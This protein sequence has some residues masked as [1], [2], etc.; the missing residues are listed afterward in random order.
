MR[1]YVLVIALSL[2]LLSSTVYA[3][4]AYIRPPVIQVTEYVKNGV[5]NIVSSFVEVKNRNAVP[6]IVH[7]ESDD[8]VQ[9]E[10]NDFVLQ[11][12][13]TRNATFYVI[14]T[15]WGGF[16]TF[17]DVTYMRAD[18]TG[19]PATVGAPMTISA[20]SNGTGINNGPP[21]AP[22]ITSPPN[23]AVIE[24]T[25]NLKW[26][27][28]SDPDG[29]QIL[30]Y[31]IVDDN[32]D[33]S[34]PVA[35]ISTI[36]LEKSV[37]LE[38]GKSYSWKVI[39]FDGK[40]S[41]SSNPGGGI[42]SND[43]PPTPTP[44]SPANGAALNNAPVLS[45]SSVADPDGDFVI[46][47]LLVDNNADFSSPEINAPA[48]TS[49]NTNGIL[50]AGTYYW[51]VRARDHAEASAYSTARSFTLTC[52]D[53]Y[54]YNIQLVSPVDGNTYNSR[55]ILVELSISRNA[56]SIYKALN[57][58]TFTTICSDCSEVSKA[59]AAREGLNNLTIKIVGYNGEEL[60]K[61]IFFTVDT[62]EPRISKIEPD[63]ESW[64]SGTLFMVKYT[65]NNIK[66]ISLFYGNGE[67]N[68]ALLSNCPNGSNVECAIDLNL[69]DYDGQQIQYYFVIRDKFNEVVSKTFV[70]NVDATPPVLNVISPENV[71]YDTGRLQITAS[72]DEDVEL[73]YSDNDDGLRRLCSDCNS[74]NRSKTFRDGAHM[75]EI[76]ATDKAGNV[77]ITIL[78][79]EVDSKEPRI[80]AI[81]PKNNGHTNGAFSVKYNEENVKSVSLFYGANA[82]NEAEVFFCP[83]GRNAVCDV[84][85]DLDDYD[86]QQIQYY[87]VVRDNF[88]EITSKTYTVNADTTPPVLNL[89][90]PVNGTH[91]SIRIIASISEEVDLEYSDNGGAFRSLCSSCISYNRTKYIGN[92][93][94]ELVVRATDPAG[95]VDEE[96]VSFTV[97]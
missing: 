5:I 56:K 37:E 55:S 87:F 49:Y 82:E 42:T 81:E 28:S 19:I 27:A 66:N 97:V 17:L 38:T 68:E 41:T 30:Y 51:K 62:T 39:A 93:F 94:H 77:A 44:I 85:V 3:L 74:Y 78:N 61:S 22:V 6:V 47:D 96:S 48:G 36:K 50:N 52:T 67:I 90:S 35:N 18:G 12:G 46:Y 89:V 10:D 25:L 83:S 31:A 60:V 92:G 11:P 45:W 29:N 69:D 16:S 32:A 8:F 7:L 57:T 73:E 23:N 34:S 72:V 14:V 88:N 43:P 58:K 86:G 80:S 59:Y 33:F 95:N 21:T 4:I 9:F 63:D 70:L 15:K 13:E 53:P 76:R 54:C 1:K 64:V 40:F 2:L 20:I 91:D 65:E 71:A 26:T 84:A 79:F 24:G 75:L